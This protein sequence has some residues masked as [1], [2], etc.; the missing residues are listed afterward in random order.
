V[1]RSYIL[2]NYRNQLIV[3]VEMQLSNNHSNEL[4]TYAD[5]NINSTPLFIKSDK[6]VRDGIFFIIT[7][8]S[9]YTIIQY[10]TWRNMVAASYECPFI[11]TNRWQPQLKIYSRYSH[12]VHSH[13][14]RMIHEASIETAKAFSSMCC[15][16]SLPG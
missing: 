5:T 11:Y 6:N 1:K 13:F 7:D 2:Y 10:R 8:T 14:N 12:H 15:L 16:P 3:K 4:C 9:Y